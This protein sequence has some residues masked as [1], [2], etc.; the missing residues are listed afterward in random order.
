M[1]L[2]GVENA[3]TRTNKRDTQKLRK[4]H[5]LGNN[6]I[7]QDVTGLWRSQENQ[8]VNYSKHQI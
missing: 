7:K 2:K 6:G 1:T 3:P 5:P 8:L 4:T